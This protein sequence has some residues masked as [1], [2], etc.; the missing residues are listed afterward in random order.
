VHPGRERAQHVR[1]VEMAGRRDD[2]RVELIELEH[3][4]DVREDIGHAE[5]LGERP[6]LRAIVVAERH[7]LRAAQPRESGQVRDLRDGSHADHTD[8]KSGF[9]GVDTVGVGG[10]LR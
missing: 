10:R 5:P 7:E 2:H 3:L 9:H 4:I 6:R 8:A 1:L